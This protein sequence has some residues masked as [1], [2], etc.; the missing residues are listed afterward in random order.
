MVRYDDLGPG[1]DV[2]DCLRAD[3][4]GAEAR[5]RIAAAEPYV[6]VEESGADGSDGADSL[7]EKGA[8]ASARPAIDA[9]DADL[10]RTSKQAWAALQTANV[11]PKMFRFGGMPVRIGGDEDD[12]M[13]IAQP[14]TEDRLSYELARS[15]RWFRT[16]E[17]GGE[18]PAAPSLRLVRD[19]LAA[20]SYP[21][22]LLLSIVQVPVFAPDGTLHIHPGYH[23][24]ARSFYAPAPG[25]TLPVVPNSPSTAD[26]ER[27]RSLILDDLLGDFPFCSEAE[28]ANAVAL[29]LDRYVRNMI[30][31][32][33]PL[34][35]IEA[36]TPG[37]GKGL[38][39]DVL[40]RPTVGRRVNIMPAANDDDEWRKRITA[41]LIQLP[42]IDL[43]DNITSA[44]DSGSL[45]AALTAPWWSDR[46]LGATEMV[47]VPVR[48][49]WIAT[50]NNPVMSTELAR[51]SVRIRLDPKVDRPWERT[52][53]R[54]NDLRGWADGHRADL[55]WSA[56]VLVRHWIAEGSPMGTHKI[57]SFEEWSAVLGGILGCGGIDG[58]LGN[59]EVFY[60]EADLEG[61]MW[62]Q[63]VGE[64]F[65]RY[66]EAEVGIADLFGV[67]AMIEG[68]DFGKGSDRSQKIAFG[69]ALNRQRDRVIGD[70]RV[71]NTRTL[72]RA[73][74]WRLL[75]S[76]NPLGALYEGGTASVSGAD[77]PDEGAGL[78]RWTA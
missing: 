1:A 3:P 26:V 30:D 60:E 53:F 38:L 6:C 7:G 65:A 9:S 62:R 54:H 36:P 58:F 22:P 41:Q 4:S 5:R 13:P 64:W 24:E 37:S 46:V 16:A 12:G 42:E 69:L 71:I 18:R 49:T 76:G 40:L 34:R 19:L 57:G 14:L 74:R 39:A 10:E 73:K 67:A 20:P 59:L 78:D 52:S 66:G 77:Q 48:C 61:A 21:L 68:F 51:R 70:Y 11:P 25:F 15:A 45:S 55:V 44:L 8:G 28:R 47:R 35:L 72:H 27:A 43:I 56:L 29:L 32:V 50:A 2:L 31:G 33:T 23:P 75:R 17:K 63:F